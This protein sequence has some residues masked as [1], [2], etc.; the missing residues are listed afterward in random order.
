MQWQMTKSI[1]LKSKG[2]DGNNME[3]YFKFTPRLPSFIS[4]SATVIAITVAAVPGVC[5]APDVN[6]LLRTQTCTAHN[7]A[8]RKEPV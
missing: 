6:T 8:Y 1:Q 2:A 7:Q 3:T 5:N 4:V